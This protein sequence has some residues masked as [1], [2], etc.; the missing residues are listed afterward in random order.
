V[1]WETDSRLVCH[2]FTNCRVKNGNVYVLVIEKING[3]VYFLKSKLYQKSQHSVNNCNIPKL[4]AIHRQ[5]LKNYFAYLF[6]QRY[7]ISHL[8]ST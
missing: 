5:G 2:G 6:I 4:A 3:M 8:Q 7:P 1:R